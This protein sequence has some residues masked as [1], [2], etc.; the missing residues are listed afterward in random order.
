MLLR[1][2]RAFDRLSTLKK[3]YQ[4]KVQNLLFGKSSTSNKDMIYGLGCY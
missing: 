3:K 1:M 2:E 4:V